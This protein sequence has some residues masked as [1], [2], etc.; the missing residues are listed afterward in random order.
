M[1]LA[2]KSD[3][4]TDVF[5]TLLSGFLKDPNGDANFKKER[6]H[7]VDFWKSLKTLR[8]VSEDN[9]V[10]EPYR[11][12]GFLVLY[13]QRPVSVLLIFRILSE[14]D[15]P[16]SGKEIAQGV[17]KKLGVTP[18]LLDTGRYY[19]DRI[20]D[21]LSVLCELRLVEKTIEALPGPEAALSSGRPKY[22]MADPV[23]IRAWLSHFDKREGI[24]DLRAVQRTDLVRLFKTRYDEKLGVVKTSEKEEVKFNAGELIRSI[25]TVGS[26]YSALHILTQIERDFHD[27]MTTREIQVLVYRALSKSDRNAAEKFMRQY[28]GPFEVVFQGR[29]EELTSGLIKRMVKEETNGYAIMQ[30][31]LVTIDRELKDYVRR[32]SLNVNEERLRQAIRALIRRRFLVFRDPHISV[33]DALKEAEACL[34]NSEEMLRCEMLEA[35]SGSLSSAA[36]QL[37]PAFLL[38]IRGLPLK[39]LK[40]NAEYLNHLLTK[41]TRTQTRIVDIVKGATPE[42]SREEIISSLL[43]L[44]EAPYSPKNSKGFENVLRDLRFVHEAAGR[45]EERGKEPGLKEAMLNIDFIS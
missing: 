10:R 12:L 45:I 15:T 8:S 17:A 29:R 32:S 3:A 39:T 21:V 31:F 30:S 26:F 23:D 35:T 24:L 6:A 27:G 41:G 4:E 33:I 14:S 11:S 38:S 9:K 18:G 2:K 16:L 5:A 19:K 25:M 20:G 1:E 13:G 43:S 36:E 28:Q 34:T 42:K 40:E 37:L 22:R 44:A 7:F